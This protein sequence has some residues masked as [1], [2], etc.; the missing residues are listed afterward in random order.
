MSQGK[1]CPYCQTENALHAMLCDACGRSLAPKRDTFFTTEQVAQVEPEPAEFVPSVDQLGSLVRN[2]LVLYM[3]GEDKPIVLEDVHEI[4]LG[5]PMVEMPGERTFDLTDYGAMMLGVSRRHVQITYS[6]GA[7]TMIDLGSTNGTL[8][9]GR[10]IPPAHSQRLRPFDQLTLGQL[11][12]TVFFKIDPREQRKFFILTDRRTI[13]PS[14]MTPHYLTSTIVPYIQALAGIQ[15]ISQEVHGQPAED[16]EVLHIQPGTQPTQV[17]L[18][19]LIND[20]VAD[21]MRQ[22][23]VPWQRIHA[24]PNQLPPDPDDVAFSSKLNDLVIS[25]AEYLLHSSSGSEIMTLQEKLVS[26]ISFIA[27]SGLEI[28]LDPQKNSMN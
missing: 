15:K 6:D 5:R 1:I 11:R 19:L 23:V 10:L 27:T 7:F 2:T 28:M 24:D 22:L 9:N 4:V 12:L 13:Q 21:I 26:L 3:S 16:V 18:S 17:R 25:V 20:E 14:S 8:L